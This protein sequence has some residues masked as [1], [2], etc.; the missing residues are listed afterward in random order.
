MKPVNTY[1]C[2]V[3]AYRNGFIFRGI[4]ERLYERN[5]KGRYL[6]GAKSAKEA[7]EILQKAIGFGSINVPKH[8]SWIY[9]HLK[10]PLKYK[11]VLKWDWCHDKEKN[12]LIDSFS[13][14]IRHAT[15][16]ITR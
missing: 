9:D 10:K 13:T 11:E 16:P 8:Q 6:V 7:K 1:V 3:D 5:T 14:D 2:Y 4:S 15:A 12:C